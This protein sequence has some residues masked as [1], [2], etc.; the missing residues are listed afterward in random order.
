MSE[1][2]NCSC[3][4]RR[5]LY[6][7]E[8]PNLWQVRLQEHNQH[9]YGCPYSGGLHAAQTHTF[10]TT[11]KPHS[12]TESTLLV[13]ATAA[14]YTCGASTWQLLH[15]QAGPSGQGQ[16]LWNGIFHSGGAIEV[17]A[18]KRITLGTQA[19]P[20]WWW[21]SAAM[22]D[23]CAGEFCCVPHILQGSRAAEGDR[24]QPTTIGT[25]IDIIYQEIFCTIGKLTSLTHVMPFSK[26]LVYLFCL[27]ASV[28]LSG[29]V[30][31]L[32][33]QY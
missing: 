5:S 14:L 8:P 30:C 21:N 1:Q 9:G 6:M 4:P 17:S 24:G 31:S 13:C 19:P 18:N 20:Q 7:S 33:R 26:S 28:L 29:F 11:T 12:T 22:W 15:I 16:L 2:V 32:S 10:C 25:C 3:G 23:W 27:C